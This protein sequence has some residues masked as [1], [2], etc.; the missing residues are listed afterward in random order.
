MSWICRSHT[1]IKPCCCYFTQEESRGLLVLLV[2]D[3]KFDPKVLYSLHDITMALS[4]K[5]VPSHPSTWHRHD[6]KY[7]RYVI[8]CERSCVS[9]A[10]DLLKMMAN[11]MLLFHLQR[12]LSYRLKRNHRS[13]TTSKS[14]EFE[15]LFLC[16]R[17]PNI[18]HAFVIWNSLWPFI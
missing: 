10:L 11:P 17:H 7:I 2:D 5:I 16:F 14:C 9:P 12:H 4:R 6:G 13:S 15:A 18:F 8:F 3:I 1:Y